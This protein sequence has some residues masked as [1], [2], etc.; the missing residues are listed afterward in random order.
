MRWPCMASNKGAG[1]ASFQSSGQMCDSAWEPLSDSRHTISPH[2]GQARPVGELVPTVSSPQQLT[3]GSWRVHPLAPL[4]SGR[5]ALKPRGPWWDWAP[6]APSC[7]LL[8]DASFFGLSFPA[9]PLPSL[10][11]SG[12][13]SQTNC[14]YLNPCLG[15]RLWGNQI[16]ERITVKLWGQRAQV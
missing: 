16:Q 2:T 12:I 14:L 10:V 13:N 5:M 9:T 6:V 8:N 11:F 15:V 3:D 7:G 1:I 4:P